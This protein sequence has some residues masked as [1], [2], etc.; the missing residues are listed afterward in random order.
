MFEVL[1]VDDAPGDARLVLEAFKESQV[2]SHLTVVGSTRALAYLREQSLSGSTKLPN[3]ILFDLSLSVEDG[4]KIL[5]EIKTDVRLK[6]IPV[7]A[8]SG[9]TDDRDI[10]RAYES[11]ANCYVTK[12]MKIDQFLHAVHSIQDFW[13]G[14]AVKLPSL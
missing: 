9:S 5:S 8:F 3:L 2:P 10:G 14:G 1:L 6:K 4:F 12:P 11:H 7:V 13:L